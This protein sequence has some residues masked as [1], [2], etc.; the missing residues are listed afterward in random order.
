MVLKINDEADADTQIQ[1][2][3]FTIQFLH[4]IATSTPNIVVNKCNYRTMRDNTC[5][6]TEAVLSGT[7]CKTAI[8]QNSL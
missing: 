1:I 7:L 4:T 3:I 5:T 6:S 8:L 2:N